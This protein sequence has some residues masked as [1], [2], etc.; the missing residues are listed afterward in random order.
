M[1]FAV[2][3]L[4][5]QRQRRILYCCGNELFYAAINARQLLRH[6][7]WFKEKGT[8]AAMTKK[9]LKALIVTSGR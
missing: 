3:L 4:I 6:P 2:F 8:C 7:R 1:S 5:W 9:V